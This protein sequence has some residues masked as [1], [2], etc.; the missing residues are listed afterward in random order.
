VSR[1]SS[2]R[3]AALE[4]TLHRED[5][6]QW[7]I[8]ALRHLQGLLGLREPAPP[9]RRLSPAEVDA[10]PWTRNLVRLI[11]VVEGSRDT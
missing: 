7:R 8:E 2:A 1:Q 3:L 4:R 9:P 6:S 5:W 11:E 10:A